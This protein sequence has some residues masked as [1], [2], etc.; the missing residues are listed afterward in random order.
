MG[1]APNPF[2]G[3]CTLATCKPRIRASAKAGDWLLGAG[4]VRAVGINRIVY[5]ARIDEVCTL[6]E[7]GSNPR[8]EAKRPAARSE[9]WRRHG[10]NIYFKQSGGQWRQRRNIHH[11]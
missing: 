6:E 9:P 2:G 11:S 3:Y 7:Y 10:D 1:F 8:F 4:S 5:A